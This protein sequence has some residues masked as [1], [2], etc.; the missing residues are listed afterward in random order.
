MKLSNTVIYN[1][2]TTF[3]IIMLE[4]RKI[5]CWFQNHVLAK[6]DIYTPEY[7]CPMRILDHEKL[8]GPHFSLMRN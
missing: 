4:T 3:I 2:L 5:C 7:R 8:R 1:C 6:S